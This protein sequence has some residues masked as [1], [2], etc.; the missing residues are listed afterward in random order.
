MITCM[1]TLECDILGDPFE[2]LVT[3]G[4]LGREDGRRLGAAVSRHKRKVRA[5][6]AMHGEQGTHTIR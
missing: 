5:V 6:S 1:H 4:A 3:T 2:Q